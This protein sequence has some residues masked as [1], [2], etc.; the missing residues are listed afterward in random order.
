MAKTKAEYMAMGCDE[1]A[2]Q[3]FAAGRKRLTAVVANADFTLTLTYDGVEKRLYDM[4]ET[5]A[6]G[7]VFAKIRAWEDF[8]RV[9]LD[10]THSV[11]WDIDPNVDSDVV[12]SNLIDLCPDSCYLDSVPVS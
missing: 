5:L 12:W 3:Y 6:R 8:R 1:R 10:E 4:R 2:A 7:G 11:C 9:Y